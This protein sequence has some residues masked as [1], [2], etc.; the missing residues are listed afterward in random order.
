M[1]VSSGGF[2]PG[3]VY[4]D[5]TNPCAICT[6]DCAMRKC[7]ALY[8][9]HMPAFSAGTTSWF[10]GAVRLSIDALINGQPRGY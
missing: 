8:D 1:L 9:V 6:L 7:T 5:W 10:E 3:S 4:W 2:E